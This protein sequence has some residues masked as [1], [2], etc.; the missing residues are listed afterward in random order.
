M[1]QLYTA[2]VNE[3]VVEAVQVAL[4]NY[5]AAH[6]TGPEVSTLPGVVTSAEEDVIRRAVLV[7]FQSLRHVQST[8]TTANQNTLNNGVAVN[9]DAQALHT[10]RAGAAASL[11]E[12]LSCLMHNATAMQDVVQQVAMC[13]RAHL[14]D[15]HRPGTHDAETVA[16]IYQAAPEVTQVLEAAMEQQLAWRESEAAA[17]R[18]AA[19]AS[20][21]S[22]VSHH[23]SAVSAAQ[24]MWLAATLVMGYLVVR[25]LFGRVLGLG[26]A[27][28]RRRRRRRTTVLIGLPGSGKTAL[29]GQLVRRMQLRE[30]RTSM[31]ENVGSLLVATERG[32]PATAPGV[33]I[34]DCPGHPRLRER[35][36]T[37]VGEAVNVVVVIDA[38]T[39]QDS[40]HEGVAALAELLLGVLQSPE[41]YGV[42]KLLFACTKRDEVTSYAAKAVRKLLEAAMVASIASRQN[43]MGRVES[44]RDSNN[45]VISSKRGKLGGGSGRRYVLSVEGGDG[46]GGGA[47]AGAARDVTRG[48]LRGATAAAV[49]A[50]GARGV[51][52]KRFSFEQLGIPL[53]FVDV[54]S[55]PHPT[56]HKYSVSPIEEF[57][58]EG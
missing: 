30:T 16:S 13:I 45:T 14:G 25:L 40:Q 54:S 36:L 7:G 42:H 57:I 44:V 55:R 15:N 24:W 27:L 32:M 22:I 48:H 35:M 18:G 56:E 5:A 46:S 58:L 17:E 9:D 20:Y 51:G 21:S 4:D 52:G 6:R 37:A 29:F 23:L 53:A 3:T 19:E 41:F 8:I 49:S 11:Q 47:C 31:R 10:A 38:V 34:V 39:V 33:R 50:A 2:L 28:S 26:D 43:A 12:A 1:S